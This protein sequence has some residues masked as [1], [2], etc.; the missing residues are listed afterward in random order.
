MLKE[1]MD[2][3]TKNACKKDMSTDT[4]VKGRR[5]LWVDVVPMATVTLTTGSGAVTGS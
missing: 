4:G 2:H 5:F 1:V 3:V